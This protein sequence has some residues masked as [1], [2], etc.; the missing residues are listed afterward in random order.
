MEFESNY[1]ELA[2]NNDKILNISQE[3]DCKHMQL[4]KHT[5]M[6]PNMSQINSRVA[7]I[8]QQVSEIEVRKKLVHGY[9][10]G[11]HQ[12]SKKIQKLQKR[13]EK[14]RLKNGKNQADSLKELGSQISSLRKERRSLESKITTTKQKIDMSRQKQKASKKAKAKLIRQMENPALNQMKHELD[15]LN[16]RKDELNLSNKTI[17]FTNRAIREALGKIPGDIDGNFANSVRNV[18]M[19][20]STWEVWKKYVAMPEKMKNELEMR[21]IYVMNRLDPVSSCQ[22][23]DIDVVYLTP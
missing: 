18:E 23:S 4:I 17:F 10:S 1:H 12:I 20:I 6:I 16:K 19:I 22:I 8:D 3:I 13:K 15:L 11:T 14:I 5:R 9:F 2:K 21:R 7:K